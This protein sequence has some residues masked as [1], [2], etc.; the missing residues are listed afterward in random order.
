MAS[1]REKKGIKLAFPLR[2]NATPLARPCLSVNSID[3]KSINKL[4]V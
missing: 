1:R 2:N 4:T 3:A